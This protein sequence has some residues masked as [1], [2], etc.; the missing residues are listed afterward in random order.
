METAR[1]EE[2]A[3]SQSRTHTRSAAA[4][5]PVFSGDT[6][7]GLTGRTRLTEAAGAARVT[8]GCASAPG[9]GPGAESRD[10]QRGA[11]RN[12]RGEATENTEA[13]RFRV[14][15]KRR[16]L[17]QGN[18][19]IPQGS[20]VNVQDGWR[21]ARVC[22]GITP[23]PLHRAHVPPTAAAAAGSQAQGQGGRMTVGATG[24]CIWDGESAQ[25]TEESLPGRCGGSRA[26]VA[27]AARAT[28]STRRWFSGANSAYKRPVEPHLAQNASSFRSVCPAPI[29]EWK[30][31]RATRLAGWHLRWRHC[32]V[33]SEEEGATGPRPA[34]SGAP[35]STGRPVLDTDLSTGGVPAQQGPT[36]APSTWQAARR[37]SSTRRRWDA[38]HL[39][40][41]NL[42]N[43]WLFPKNAS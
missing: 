24:H 37:I 3:L 8:S 4:L 43:I 38:L 33:G 14:Y 30:S 20:E 2:R 1:C 12:P 21:N 5:S 18:L 32:V 10:P 27:P 40:V 35:L 19:L 16:W 25:G 29:S 28:A 17:A 34:P 31:E 6:D 36:L 9:P 7:G 11:P 39:H 26:T 22:P 42:M 41:S 13:W 23:G 15:Q